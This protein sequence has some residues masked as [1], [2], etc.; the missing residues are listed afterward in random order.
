MGLR[1]RKAQRTRERIV[2]ESLTL[3]ES[4]GYEQT[5]M[6][7]IAEAADISPSTLYRYF[8]TKDSIILAPFETFADKLSSVFL[9]YAADRPAGEALGEAIFAMLREAEEHKAETLLVRSIID[10]SALPRARLWDYLDQQLKELSRQLAQKLGLS[11][12]DLR[13]V[14]TARLMV[15]VVGIAADLWRESG[16][17]R[18]SVAIAGEI[19]QLFK[20]N[21]VLIP[22]RPSE[23]SGGE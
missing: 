18:S 1:E 11:P 12:G 16:G 20:Q 22:R 2:A 6:E 9:R 14:V 17:T 23:R 7:S 5:T 21:Q 19:M 8:P 15:M 4:V 3:F 10:R 13:I